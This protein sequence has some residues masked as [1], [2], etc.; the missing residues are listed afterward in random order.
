MTVDQGRHAREMARRQRLISRVRGFIML[1][2][3]VVLALAIILVDQTQPITNGEDRVWRLLWLSGSAF[4][5]L[6]FILIVTD[7]RC[8]RYLAA[9]RRALRGDSGPLKVVVI[10]GFLSRLAFGFISFALPLYAHHLGMSLSLIGVL[11]ATNAAVTVLLKPLMGM[12][13]DR[14]GVRSAYLVAVS[15]RTCVVLSLV[16][17]T[18]P[19]HLFGARALHGVA[20]ALRDPSSATVLAALGGK[21]AVAQRF[22]WYQTTKT[23]A[24]AAGGFSSGILLTL[25]FG[26]YSAVFL[27][28]AVLSGL[29][30]LLVL[31]GLRGPQVSGLVLPRTQKRA[32]IPQALRRALLPYAGL[33]C[34]INGTA[35]LMAN[36]LPVLAVSYMGLSE[37]AAS[38]LYLFTATASLSGPVWGWVADRVSLKLVLGIRAIGNTASSLIWLFFPSYPGLVVGRV[39]DD[40]GKAAFRPAWGAVMAEVSALDPSR[41]GQTLAMMST[42][43]DIGELGA[44]IL[45]GLIWS[46]LGLPALLVIRAGAGLMTEIYAWTLGR[47]IILGQ[48]EAA[49]MAQPLSR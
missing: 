4:T 41:R 6:L 35:Y 36:L 40:L 21:K 49:E 15:L 38:S 46:S 5:V 25:L 39:T 17:A 32:L 18:T 28:S 29:P 10:E 30:I 12:V 31:A 13:I 43:E 19:L 1:S 14:I 16:F 11:L 44:P 24:G 20:I 22:A 37:A 2:F 9:P 8:R 34:A 42:A 3:T 33:G 26:N 47:R 23:V 27:V 48:G 7:W 45:A